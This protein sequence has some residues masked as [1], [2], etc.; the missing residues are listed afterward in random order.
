MSYKYHVHDD[1][2]HSD[3]TQCYDYR[4]Y[5]H[6]H[7]LLLLLPPLLL[8]QLLLLLLLFVSQQ[9]QRCG[10]YKRPDPQHP[11]STR[12][13]GRSRIAGS[14]GRS[15]RCVVG[16]QDAAFSDSEMCVSSVT[17]G[18][19]STAATAHAHAATN[20]AYATTDPARA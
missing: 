20:T 17:S 4:N 7:V 5:E 16:T 11:P 12:T 2:D 9:Q 1:Y 8:L 6:H 3:R 15:P 13:R 10:R 19:S 14:I 18:H